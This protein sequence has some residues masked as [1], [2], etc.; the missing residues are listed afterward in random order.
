MVIKRA[1]VQLLLRKGDG[2][3]RKGR[4]EKVG[5]KK[6][7]RRKWGLFVPRPVLCFLCV[8]T[9]FWWEDGYTRFPFHLRSLEF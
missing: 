8:F 7:S 1:Y 5:E 4:G 2:R 9:G 3:K 6:K